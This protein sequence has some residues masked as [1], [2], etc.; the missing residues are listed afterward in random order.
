MIDLATGRYTAAEVQRA[1][2]AAGG[3]RRVWYR[4]ERLNAYKIKLGELRMETGSIEQ[5]ANASIMRTGR[6]TVRDE[7]G[8]NWHAELLRPIFC[9]EMPDGGTAEYPLGVFYMPTITKSGY[10]HIYREIEAYD[11]TMLL[12]DD[13]VPERY[14]IARGTKYTSALSGI[15]SSVGVHDAIIEPSDSVTE[16]TL[17][18]EAGTTKGEIV[19][20]LMDADNY[21][22]LSADA[23]G[24]WVCRKDRDPR[25]RFAE[26]SYK[27]D[28]MSVLLPAQTL[29]EDVYGLPNVFIGIVSRPDRTPMSFFYEITDSSSPLAAVNRGGRRIADTKIYDDAAS[30]IALEA[31]VRRRA[32]RAA[33]YLSQLTFET[34]AMP[35]HGAEDVLWLEAGE[36]RGKYLET[37]WTLPLEPGSGMTHEAQKEDTL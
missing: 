27:A 31:A 10:K 6:F 15:F 14:S 33:A 32:G 5:D 30:A 3:S 8:V 1:L 2:H 29:V 17:E 24:R 19:K 9:L 7:A 22:P 28:E 25:S 11:T 36:V 20:Q 16:T 26:Y 35:H 13:Q 21:A 4:L 23:W 34:A 12:W 37:K 18:W